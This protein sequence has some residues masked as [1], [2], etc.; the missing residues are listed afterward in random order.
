MEN[1]LYSLTAA[2]FIGLSFVCLLLIF[3]GLRHGLQAAGFAPSRQNR[4]FYGTL[5]AV[6]GWILSVS[7]LASQG[8]FADFT[9]VP[10]R[11]I[12]ILIPFVVLLRLTFTRTLTTICNTCPSPGSI[13][14]R[15]S[16][17]R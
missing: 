2:G 13:T 17:C 5:L 16:G 1:P 14:C 9:G 12:V 3:Y 11:M 6:S 4:I 10:P 7:L 15:L 8:F